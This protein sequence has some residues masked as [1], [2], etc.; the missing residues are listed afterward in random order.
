MSLIEK[1]KL[2]MRIGCEKAFVKGFFRSNVED[3]IEERE[4]I[5][6]HLDY[7]INAASVSFYTFEQDIIP[8]QYGTF[9][10]EATEIPRARIW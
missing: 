5:L 3:K 9:R 6:F 10:E 4:G 7:R 1:C 2:I 8:L